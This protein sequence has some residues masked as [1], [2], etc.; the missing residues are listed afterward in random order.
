MPHP[1]KLIL[2]KEAVPA[3]P[4]E[5][6]LRHS[7]GSPVGAPVGLPT[8]FVRDREFIQDSG[9]PK[10]PELPLAGVPPRARLHC[11]SGGSLFLLFIIAVLYGVT[12]ILYWSFS[13]FLIHLLLSKSLI[14]LET[15]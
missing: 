15:S 7:G 10:A 6:P 1:L 13:Q 8:S 12:F 5:G 9:S 11:R 4:H 2:G 3:L 14:L